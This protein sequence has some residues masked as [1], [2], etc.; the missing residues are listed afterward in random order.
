MLSVYDE[1]WGQQ[2]PKFQA[3]VRMYV[4]EA[5]VPFDSLQY[6]IR[7]S[8]TL[9]TRRHSSVS[10]LEARIWPNARL[11]LNDGYYGASATVLLRV[12]DQPVRR[13]SRDVCFVEA[14]QRLAVDYQALAC[15]TKDR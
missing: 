13:K 10:H 5:I 15:F 2:R 6:R 1:R 11:L 7:T 14:F 9:E 4:L 3:A 12:F 8:M